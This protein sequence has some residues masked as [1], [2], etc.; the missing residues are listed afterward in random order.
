MIKSLAGLMFGE[1]LF[2]IDGTIKVSSHGGRDRRA[3]S[4]NAVSSH[5]GREEKQKRPKPVPQVL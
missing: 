3:K 5:G 2:F 4:D 1:G